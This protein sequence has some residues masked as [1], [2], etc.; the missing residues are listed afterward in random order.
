[1]SGKAKK[2]SQ[3]EKP[4][5]CDFLAPFLYI[6]MSESTSTLGNMKLVLSRVRVLPENSATD[7]PEPRPWTNGA[8]SMSPGGN[9]IILF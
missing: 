2:P 8:F 5:V 9:T 6:G 7:V 1:M 3:K 4:E